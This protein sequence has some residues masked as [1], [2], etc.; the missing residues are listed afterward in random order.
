MGWGVCRKKCSRRAQEDTIGQMYN[1]DL[2]NV[3]MW[4]TLDDVSLR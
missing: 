2:T 3:V 1:A 4:L